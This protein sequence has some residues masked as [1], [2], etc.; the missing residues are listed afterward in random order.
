LQ[1]GAKGNKKEKS[2]RSETHLKSIAICAAIVFFGTG[3]TKAGTWT[4]FDMPGASR[5]YIYGINGNNVIGQY[6]DGSHTRG[7]LYN[8]TT[9]TRLDMPG[10]TE[11][12]IYGVDGSNIVGE[13][14]AFGCHGFLYNGTTWTTLSY[15]GAGTTGIYGIDGSNIVGQYCDSSGGWHSFLYNGANWTTLDMPGALS[16]EI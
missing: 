12:W 15:P 7:F 2:M 6:W 9:W 3:Y 5:T 16:T 13:Y 4:T 10:A 14:N 1:G 11:T 8:G